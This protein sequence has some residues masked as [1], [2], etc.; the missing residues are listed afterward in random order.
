MTERHDLRISSL[1]KHESSDDCTLRKPAE[2]GRFS[3]DQ[4]R[5]FHHDRSSMHCFTSPTNQKNF[6]H[7]DL[8]D[9]YGT[10][11]F[12]KRNDDVKEGLDN[13][14]KWMLC[15]KSRFVDDIQPHKKLKP[16]TEEAVIGYYP[17]FVTWRGH[18]TKFL[19]T[20]YENRDGWIMAVQKLG[21]TI[22]ICEIE[23]KKARQKRTNQSDKEKLMTYW[24]VRFEGYMTGHFHK[25]GTQPVTKFFKNTV[26]NTNIAF[27][28][29]LRT[30][31][32]GRHSA[33]YGAEVDC[34]KNV[35]V[36]NPPDCYIEL[37]T[38]RKITSQRQED[39]FYRHKVIV[40]F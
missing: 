29:V 12:I 31:V 23:S 35:E 40:I 37:K 16:S 36:L 9:G 28:S 11:R 33:V 2:V 3:L 14:L 20:P 34:C 6:P 18:L 1:V 7:L 17:D 26:I 38:S 32:H 22:Y 39:N 15:N 25:P 5:E 30:R 19:C 27:C 24:G 13:M 8:N 21:S 4:S 10:E